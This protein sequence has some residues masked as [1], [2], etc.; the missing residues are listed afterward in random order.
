MTEMC[1][2]CCY[3]NENVCSL[4]DDVVEYTDYCFMFKEDSE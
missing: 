4:F 2:D 1:A 3:R